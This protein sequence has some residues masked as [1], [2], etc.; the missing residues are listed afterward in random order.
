[1][2]G[3]AKII[4]R[5]DTIFNSPSSDSQRWKIVLC[6]SILPLTFFFKCGS[7]F[8]RGL[9]HGKPQHLIFKLYQGMANS[10]FTH[11]LQRAPQE[12]HVTYKSRTWVGRVTFIPPNH[13][14][15]IHL[16]NLGYI[17]RIHQCNYHLSI[18]IT[19]Y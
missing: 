1:M 17:Y 6:A 14:S 19:M 11:L 18:V 3:F 13:P 15:Y 2:H 12:H 8:V 4:T 7:P 10:S 5:E 9:L 16:T